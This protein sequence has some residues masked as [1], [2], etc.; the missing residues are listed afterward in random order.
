MSSSLVSFTEDFL[1]SAVKLFLGTYRQEQRHSPLLPSYLLE[2][3]TPIRQALA[4][5]LAHPGVAIVQGRQVLAYML[6]GDQFPWKGQQAALVPEYGH[7]AVEEN[8]RDLYWRLYMALA[9]TWADQHIHLH[10]LGHFAHDPVL[11]DTIYH[12]GF[13]AILAERLRDLSAVAG[14]PEVVAAITDCAAPAAGT[15][16]AVSG[17]PAPRCTRAPS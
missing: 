11:H 15:A 13:G 12:L 17:P 2:D 6:T 4:A 8:K 5:R 14:A 3:P 9:Q 16:C 1:E 7:A 10:L